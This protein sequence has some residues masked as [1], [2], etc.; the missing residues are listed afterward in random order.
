MRAPAVI[1]LAPITVPVGVRFENASDCPWPA[2]AVRPDG[3]VGLTYQ[4]IDPAGR[5]GVPPQFFSRLLGD[6]APHTTVEDT[7][8]VVPEGSQAGR[9]RLDVLLQ[10]HGVVVPLARASTE[11]EL[12]P[13]AAAP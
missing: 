1:A 13:F 12:R 9:W 5:P 8:I 4:W 6:V 11:V 2:L 3:L 7:V 10:Q